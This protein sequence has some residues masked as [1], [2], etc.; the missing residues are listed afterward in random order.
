MGRF[1]PV[2]E[3]LGEPYVEAHSA[4]LRS[5]ARRATT[6]RAHGRNWRT[7]GSRRRLSVGPRK[8]LRTKDLAVSDRNGDRH[9]QGPSTV[10]AGPSNLIGGQTFG[11]AVSESSGPNVAGRALSG[12]LS[13]LPS[14]S[15]WVWVYP[16]SRYQS[17][18]LAIYPVSRYQ[19]GLSAVS[20]KRHL[21]ARTATS[22]QR[23]RQSAVTAR[24]LP[25]QPGPR[26]PRPA[27]PPSLQRGA[28]A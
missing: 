7:C 23:P 8:W 5:G 9:A 27:L 15:L 11:Q 20:P 10:Q 16:V 14:V 6:S 21:W 1:W 4:T 13:G 26:Q 17:L 18:G 24:A 22:V 12:L 2:L 3:T 28:T 19:G 25:R